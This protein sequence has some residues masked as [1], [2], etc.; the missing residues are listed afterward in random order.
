MKISR[1]WLQRQMA[2]SLIVL[3]AVP[4][5]AQTQQPPPSQQEGTSSVGPDQRQ[6]ANRL[7]GP[8]GGEAE[9]VYP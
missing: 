5:L 3:L 7:N 4:L 6:T 9:S 2:G 1:N 8:A